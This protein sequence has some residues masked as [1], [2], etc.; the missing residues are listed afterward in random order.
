M[1]DSGDLAFH[2]FEGRCQPAVLDPRIVE[3]RVFGLAGA[4]FLPGRVKRFAV[5]PPQYIQGLG[6][7]MAL[8]EQGQKNA[9]HRPIFV[10]RDHK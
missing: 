7:P 5:C 6:Q 8:G 10:Q 1:A 2:C 4:Q 9:S 3:G